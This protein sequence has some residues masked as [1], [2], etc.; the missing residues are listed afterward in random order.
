MLVIERDWRLRKL[1]RANLEVL[2]LEVR[3]AVSGRHGLQ[4]IRQTPPRPDPARSRSARRG[5]PS[6]CSMT[7]R[8]ASGWVPGAHHSAVR[9][10]VRA[11]I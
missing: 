5:C 1:I 9:R 3:E 8:R 7:V 6:R 4:L 11:A 10:A 2:G